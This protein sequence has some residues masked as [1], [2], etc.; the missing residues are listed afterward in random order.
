MIKKMQSEAE[1]QG[2]IFRSVQLSPQ[3]FQKYNFVILK[4]ASFL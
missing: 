4:N 2:K 3:L 1:M